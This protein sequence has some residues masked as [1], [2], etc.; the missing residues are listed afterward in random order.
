MDQ[1]FLTRRKLI[2]QIEIEKPFNRLKFQD[3]EASQLPPTQIKVE[4]PLGHLQF[5]IDIEK[6]FNCLRFQ[7]RKVSWLPP[8]QIKVEKSLGYPRSDQ[9]REAYQSTL[10]SELN[11]EASQSPQISRFNSSLSV[12]KQ[13]KYS[14]FSFFK[15]AK[16]QFYVPRFQILGL[17]NF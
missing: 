9:D 12:V 15:I 10:D 11:R 3:R 17:G 14:Q 5:Q 2:I 7:D 6:P 8:I 16:H 1:Q 13:V 4:K